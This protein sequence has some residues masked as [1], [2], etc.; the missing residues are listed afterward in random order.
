MLGTSFKVPRY[1]ACMKTTYQA[2]APQA[3]LADRSGAPTVGAADDIGEGLASSLRV[4]PRLHERLPI[5]R[6]WSARPEP[7]ITNKS[8]DASCSSVDV[9]TASN[10]VTQNGNGGMEGG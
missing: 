7:P 6:L 1:I 2:L 9:P 8:V 4:L 3:R 5:S 10:D